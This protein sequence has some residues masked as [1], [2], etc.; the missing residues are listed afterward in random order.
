MQNA[1]KI[2]IHSS[3]KYV[4]PARRQKMKR[5]SIRAGDVVRELGLNGRRPAVCSALK[6]H[7]FLQHNNLRL[8]E[9]R[10]PKSGQST[11]VIYTYEFVDMKKSDL[12]KEDPW[13]RLRGALKSVFRELGG[14]EAYLRNERDNFYPPTE[15]Q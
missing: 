15:S 7:K 4:L 9:I 6:G 10:G 3:K 2:R 8:I 14:G 1:D 12:P 5:F 13:I 11:T